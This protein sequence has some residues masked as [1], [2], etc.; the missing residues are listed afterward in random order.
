MGYNLTL[1]YPNQNLFVNAS[2]HK[3][4]GVGIDE[5]LDIETRSI[6][7][8]KVF[9]KTLNADTNKPINMRR[10]FVDEKGNVIPKKAVKYFIKINGREQEVKP[11]TMTKRLIVKTLINNVDIEQFIPYSVYELTISD[12]KDFN[13]FNQL[14]R[15]AEFLEQNKKV[16]VAKYSFG[17]SFKDYYA[18]IKPI[19]INNQ[20]TFKVIFCENK[21]KFNFLMDKQMTIEVNSIENFKGF[22]INNCLSMDNVTEKNVMNEKLS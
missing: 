12:E 16:A 5:P 20:F 19:F 2:I 22:N 1:E 8:D 14:L 3:I 17:R 4:K 21:I 7:G 10:C 13:S 15:F 9:F 6:K 11:F 18:L